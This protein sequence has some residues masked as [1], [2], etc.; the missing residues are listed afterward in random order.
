MP[1]KQRTKFNLWAI[2]VGNS[3]AAFGDRTPALWDCWEEAESCREDDD[4]VTVPVAVTIKIL[5]RKRY[6]KRANW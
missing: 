6:K 3:F 4:H 5:P 2:K 1:V